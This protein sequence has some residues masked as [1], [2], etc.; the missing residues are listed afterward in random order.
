MSSRDEPT[1][2]A[3]TPSAQFWPSLQL[4]LK[5]GYT[6]RP[7]LM[8]GDAVASRASMAARPTSH[9]LPSLPMLLSIEP[10][11]SIVIITLAGMGSALNAVAS[12]TSGTQT[13]PTQ[14]SAAMQSS[15][16]S[17]GELGSAGAHAPAFAQ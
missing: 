7:K 12:H 11:R 6:L 2:S 3:T 4:W 8:A 5:P 13:M 16:V 17:Q 15:S 14:R 9:L 1:G 10:E